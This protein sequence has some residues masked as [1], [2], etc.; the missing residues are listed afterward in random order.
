[1]MTTIRRVMLLVTMLLLAMTASAFA[2]TLPKTVVMIVPSDGEG[3]F[4]KPFKAKYVNDLVGLDDAADVRDYGIGQPFFVAIHVTTAEHQAIA[5]KLASKFDV[6]ALPD[7][8]GR[9]SVTALST[10]KERL[11]GMKIPARDSLS[12][13]N[14][15]KDVA[16]LLAGMV[17]FAQQFEGT[18]R[19]YGITRPTSWFDAP[20]SLDDTSDDIFARS[21]GL[22][23]LLYAAPWDTG[24]VNPPTFDGSITVREYLTQFNAARK[25]QGFVLATSTGEEF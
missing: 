8:P 16:D 24:L 5:D 23:D 13:A 22:R 2:Q 1:M 11:E 14:T 21:P 3:T 20:L 10:I 25:A 6:V 9:V 12:T 4:R 18:Q 7:L 15:W 17:V 19:D